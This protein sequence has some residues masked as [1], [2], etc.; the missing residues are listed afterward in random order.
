[1]LKPKLY[2]YF[3]IH[4]E[5]TVQNG[6]LFKAKRVMVTTSLHQDIL[7]HIHDG[8]LGI[9]FCVRRA[10]DNVY[11]PRMNQE[12]RDY[13]SKCTPCCAH[14]PEQ[15]QEPMLP[16][17]VP[18]RPWNKV[19]MDLFQFRN[20]DFLI[21]VNYC[22]G[23]YEVK[24]MQ[25]TYASVII[26]VLKSQFANHGF[27]QTVVSD[28]GPQFACDEFKIFTAAWEFHHVTSSPHHPKSNGGVEAAVNAC[29]SPI[30]KTEESR[31]DVQLALLAAH[32]TPV[33][34]FDASPVQL[35]SG[36]RTHSLLPQH[37]SLQQPSIPKNI[38]T[39]R[40]KIKRKQKYYHDRPDL[41][42]GSVVRMRLPGQLES[43]KR[44]FLTVHIMSLQMVPLT[45][46]TVVICL[47]HQQTNHS[48]PL[49][50]Y[51]RNLPT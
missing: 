16:H 11:W 47:S 10:C 34:G 36:R 42:V 38:T 1:M 40:T 28:N 43:V 18:N 29:K 24:S 31:E 19:A 14:R 39:K 49:L 15:G 33:E 9:Q 46:K 48:L 8:H 41:P 44:S 3:H 2:P 13:V 25:T 21:T 5:T 27:P 6:L 23:F 50:K 30:K 32:N 45:G 26:Q 22:S 17:E 35:L 51:P 20:K 4:D 12:V 7:K 37:S